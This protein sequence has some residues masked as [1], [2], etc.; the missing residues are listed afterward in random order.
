MGWSHFEDDCSLMDVNTTAHCP[1]ISQLW[2]L[3][4]SQSS[5]GQVASRTTGS[6][7]AGNAYVYL[8]VEATPCTPRDQEVQGRRGDETPLLVSISQ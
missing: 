3:L 8:R 2:G 5:A 6:S 1:L 4:D 7:N